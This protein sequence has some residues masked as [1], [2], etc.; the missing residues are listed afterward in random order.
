MV[1]LF[2]LHCFFCFNLFL[3][4]SLHYKLSYNWSMIAIVGDVVDLARGVIVSVVAA[5]VSL[6]GR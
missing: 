4:F 1:L 6:K 5:I 3:I 2:M